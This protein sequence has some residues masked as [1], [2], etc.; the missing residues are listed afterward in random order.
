MSDF[1]AHIKAE[2]G[3]LTHVEN[4]IK[5][6]G[7]TEIKLTN[8]QVGDVANFTKS[9]QN[10]LNSMGLKVDFSKAEASAKSAAQNMGNAFTQS[11]NQAS[12]A[13]Q[14]FNQQANSAS[15]SLVRMKSETLSNNISL[16]L[17]NNSEAA[18]DYGA[19]LN[20]LHEKL[21]KNDDPQFLSEANTTFKNIKSSAQEAGVATSG[22][23]KQA[24]QAAEETNKIR[25]Q[26]LGNKVQAWMNQNQ[27][28]AQAYATELEQLQQ[29]IREVGNAGESTTKV[30]AKFQ[31][32]QSR[33]KAAGLT[34][35]SF[36]E[37]LKNIAAQTIGITSVAMAIRK[38][39]QEVKEAINTVV[40]LDTALVDLQKTT[41]MDN[42]DLANSIMMLMKR[43]RN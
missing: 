43:Q 36:V 29:E 16:W 14:S 7:K 8:V 31:E 4:Q 11:M 41:T 38:V 33:A 3:N 12:S 22:F 23:A 9:I 27:K 25:A 10:A 21:V 40:E 34:T 30:S 32:I 42:N 24:R 26:N 39:A 13:A 5:N 35:N 2:L 20:A 6:L 18:K 37:S 1:T 19:A 15:Q 28:A 17:K